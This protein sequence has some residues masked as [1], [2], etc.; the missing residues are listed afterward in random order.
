MSEIRMP[1]QNDN[2]LVA[3]TARKNGIPKYRFYRFVHENG[4]ERV[5]R[6][7]Y[8]KE[9]VL[10]DE[11]F[12]ISQRCPEAVFSHDEAFYYHG[13][14]D[15]EPFVHTVTV[16]SGYNAHRIK[17]DGKC[18]VYYVKKEFLAIGK[19]IVKDNFGNDIPVYNLERTICDLVR[20]RNSIERQEFS[21]VLKA[22]IARKDKN[23]NLLMEYSRNFHIENII[24]RYMEVLL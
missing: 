12:I 1:F 7:V 20:S 5:A 10:I 19:T 8:S 22:Y 11:L 16:Y 9:D 21:S 2:Y 14:S 23:L 3:E 4:F 13:L 24:R 6:G 15:R 17:A 18:K